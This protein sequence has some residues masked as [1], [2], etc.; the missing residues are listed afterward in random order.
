MTTTQNDCQ[1]PQMFSPSPN[2]ICERDS[3][4]AAAA[5]P[6]VLTTSR[7][8][9]GLQLAS[10]NSIAFATKNAC[11]ILLWF[12]KL[13]QMCFPRDKGKVTNKMKNNARQEVGF[14]TVGGWASHFSSFRVWVSHLEKIGN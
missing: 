5:L 14:I 1:K 11:T 13:I 4:R 3:P 12:S 9:S 2:C 10:G 8:Q 6:G 7:F